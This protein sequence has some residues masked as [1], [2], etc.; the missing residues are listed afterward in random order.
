MT[1]AETADA[2][3]MLRERFAAAG[4]DPATLDVCD[5]L[6]AIDGSVERS[7]EQVPAMAE[8]G[9]NVIRVH[10]RWFSKTP[11]EVLPALESV[12]RHFEPHRALRA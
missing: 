7:M 3:A 12:V 6:P 2:I 5:G 10:L 8:A 11:D 1:L 9:V 4:R